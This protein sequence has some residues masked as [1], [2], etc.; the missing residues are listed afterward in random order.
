MFS[1][2]LQVL[3]DLRELAGRAAHLWT[4]DDVERL[5]AFLLRQPHVNL[6]R[7]ALDVLVI[8]ATAEATTCFT[9]HPGRHE[10]QRS[11]SPLSTPSRVNIYSFDFNSF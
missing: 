11:V 9:M 6:Q 5:V 4:P 10:G 1:F 7:R 3:A 8:L 2:G